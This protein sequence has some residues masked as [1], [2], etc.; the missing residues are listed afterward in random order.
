[1]AKLIFPAQTNI[2]IFFLN[3]LPPSFLLK[4]I[5]IPYFSTCFL[6]LSCL[7]Q[8]TYL[9]SQPA[10]SI[11]PAQ[12]NLHTLFLNLLPPSFLLKPIN[13][14]YFSTC[15]PHLSCSSQSTYLI[16]QPASPIFP[17]QANQH[18]LFLNL[19]PPCSL[20]PPFLPLTPN[21]KI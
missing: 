11:F 8:S 9:I 3:L 4:P 15:F 13:I 12:A 21:I 6:H 19:L 5:Y 10:S 17:A 2:H 1:M 16:S 14:P 18:T 7:S 20:Q